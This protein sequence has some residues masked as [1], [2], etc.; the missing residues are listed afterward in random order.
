MST[1]TQSLS[2]VREKQQTL[3]RLSN[4][5]SGD[6]AAHK[7]IPRTDLPDTAS[8]DQFVLKPIAL[9]RI[10]PKG[11][12][13]NVVNEGERCGDRIAERRINAKATD[14][15]NAIPCSNASNNIKYRSADTT[16]YIVVIHQRAF[17]RDCFVRCLETS[18]AGHDVI[19]FESMRSWKNRE[20]DD[21][22][23][24]TVIVYFAGG[25]DPSDVLD[26]EVLE[27]AAAE[28]PMVIVS[29]TDDVNDVVRAFKSGVRGY[30]PTSLPFNV[31][32]EAVR[33]VE[34]GGTFVP[35]SSLTSGE[36]KPQAAS[37]AN[38]LLTERQLMVVGALCQGMA[39]K[40]I[41]YELS[42]SEHTVKVHI[43]HIM[44]RLNARN[45]TEVAIL[46]KGF[47]NFLD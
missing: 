10:S 36:S 42:M 4:Q 39:N 31:V 26:L 43:R 32:V 45:R 1:N 15:A 12:S 28:A 24:P 29:D 14:G 19:A 8:S 41:A 35:V 18:Y 17:I 6:A 37:K 13:A 21:G 44:R 2:S 30:I 38:D 27:A 34:A 23:P 40:Q 9:K 33:L 11:N 20:D 3:R 7:I 16:P 47:C 22:Y 46:S 5:L 25:G